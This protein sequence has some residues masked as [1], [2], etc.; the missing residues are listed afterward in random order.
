MALPQWEG[1]FENYSRSF[2]YKNRG[3]AEQTLPTRDDALQECAVV[4]TRII[5][6][7]G[8]T[9]TEPRHFMALYKT[10]L[11]NH[12][13]DLVRKQALRPVLTP[14]TEEIEKQWKEQGDIDGTPVQLLWRQASRE[15]KAVLTKIANGPQEIVNLLLDENA[16]NTNLLWQRIAQTP[17]EHDLVAELKDLL[18][19]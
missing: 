11:A 19:P 15:L 3:R 4:F 18:T 6:K 13:I 7:Y 1:T 8:T 14:M 12:W 16:P 5:S 9:V 17:C 2:V 10:A